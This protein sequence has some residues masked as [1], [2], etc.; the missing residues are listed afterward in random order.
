MILL[1]LIVTLPSFEAACCPG[2]FQ[3]GRFHECKDGF[4]PLYWQCCGK[5]PCNIFCC[6]CQC[7]ERP[8]SRSR[9]V[10]DMKTDFQDV[11]MKFNDMDVNRDQKIDVQEAAK[12]LNI[13]DEVGSILDTCT[14][15]CTTP[16]WFA[17]MDEDGNGFIE[18]E[19]FDGDVTEENFSILE[20]NSLQ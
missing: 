12:Y 3:Q 14:C 2:P 13:K 7:R 1:F 19:E 16:G 11:I 17:E 5:G 10:P 8:G 6:N 20:M 15:N 18:P 4:K 9:T